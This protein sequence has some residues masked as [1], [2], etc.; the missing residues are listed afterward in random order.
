MLYKVCKQSVICKAKGSSSTTSS[1][2]A[3]QLSF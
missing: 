2:G 3:G 1:A